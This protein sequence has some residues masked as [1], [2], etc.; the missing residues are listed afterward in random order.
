MNKSLYDYADDI[1]KLWEE[2]EKEFGRELS[3]DERLVITCMFLDSETKKEG[4]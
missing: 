2:I 1:L 4:L 3:E